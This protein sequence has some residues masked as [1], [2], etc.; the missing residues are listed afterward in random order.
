MCVEGGGGLGWKSV[1]ATS[2]CGAGI[3]E[4]TGG[5]GG[6]EGCMSA[7]AAAAA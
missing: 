5:G 3:V 7:A 1:A 4:P 6:P 2:G